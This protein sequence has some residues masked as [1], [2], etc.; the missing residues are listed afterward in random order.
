MIRL[1]TLLS[2][3]TLVVGV[4]GAFAEGVKG[5]AA[6]S[7]MVSMQNGDTPTGSQGFPTSDLSG[8]SAGFTVETGA[9][10][11][12]TFGLGFE[13]SVPARFDAVQRT[14]LI[15]GRYQLEASSH[16]DIVLS[17]LL[18]FSVPLS[19]RS[20]LGVVAG[21]SYIYEDT[22][23]RTAVA[24]EILG[25]TFGPFGPETQV[26]RWTGGATAGMD[27]DVKFGSHIDLVP[28]VRAYWVDRADVA[29]TIV[30]GLG[31]LIVRPALGLRFIF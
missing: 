12:R 24:T 8:S 6:I 9:F 11:G 14:G 7:G 21:S 30:L 22:L 19:E 4:S 29:R 16:R 23:R 26:T 17:A 3:A 5:Y 18:R 1:A 31:P 25:G 27:I 10:M 28:Q 13:A 15:G 2:I 20:R